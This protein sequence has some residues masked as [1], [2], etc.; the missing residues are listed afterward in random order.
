MLYK[1]DKEELRYIKISYVEKTLQILGAIVLI[2]LL[3]MILT[4]VDKKLTEHQVMVITTQQNAFSEEKFVNK[5]KEL[6]FPFPNIVYAQAILESNRFTSSIFKENNNIFGMRLATQR[7]TSAKGENNTYAY[8][9][10]WTESLI[11]YAL[12]SANYLSKLKTEEDYYNYLQQN[13]AEDS[14]YVE[15]LKEIVKGL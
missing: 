11:D 3:L 13:Y 2:L 14:R 5:I 7:I 6:N 4:R 15:K 1:Y 10:H 9:S 8:Y 12:Y